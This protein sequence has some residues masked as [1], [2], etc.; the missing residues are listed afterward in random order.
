MTQNSYHY[1]ALHSAVWGGHLAVVKFL[2]E[3]LKYPPDIAGQQN[4]TPLQMAILKKHFDIA[5]HMKHYDIAQYLQKHSIISYI[6][7]AI[8]MMRHLGL[9]K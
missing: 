4:M 9:L 7:A 6:Y 8:G 2:V 3:E 1:T 5:R